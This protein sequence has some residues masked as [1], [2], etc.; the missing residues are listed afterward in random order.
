[1]RD[2]NIGGGGNHVRVFRLCRD[3][4]KRMERDESDRGERE[5]REREGETREGRE[6][7]TEREK[8]MIKREMK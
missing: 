2:M 6:K 5:K 3:T 1:M 4:R 8:Y 7:E